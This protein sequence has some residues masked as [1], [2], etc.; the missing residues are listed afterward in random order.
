MDSTP[1]RLASAM[2]AALI[3]AWSMTLPGVASI[4]PSSTHRQCPAQIGDDFEVPHATDFR[5]S[6]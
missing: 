5:H 1:Q 6:V 2:I 3:S 4:H